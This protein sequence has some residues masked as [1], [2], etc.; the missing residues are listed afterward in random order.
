MD[1]MMQ[2]VRLAVTGC[3]KKGSSTRKI[4]LPAPAIHGIILIKHWIA[5]SSQ[6]LAIG[7]REPRTWEKE[8]RLG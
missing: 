5:I 2:S 6:F 1:E 4:V 8:L 3:T 7:T